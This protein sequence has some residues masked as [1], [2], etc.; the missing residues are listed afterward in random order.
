MSSNNSSRREL[1]SNELD[2]VS[3]GAGVHIERLETTVTTA[4]SD[5]LLGPGVLN[6]L[7]K[8]ILG[9]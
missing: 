5:G 8:S 1:T 9:L 6:T 7:I 2:D 3:G 4:T